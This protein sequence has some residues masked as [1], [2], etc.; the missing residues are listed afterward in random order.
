MDG[1]SASQASLSSRNVPVMESDNWPLSRKRRSRKPQE[2]F[3]RQNTDG[4]DAM[5]D[6]IEYG[7]QLENPAMGLNAV[8]SAGR[9]ISSLTMGQEACA[10]TMALYQ[11]TVEA[12]Q[13]QRDLE[14]MYSNQYDSFGMNAAMGLSMIRPFGNFNCDDRLYRRTLQQ[15]EH[16]SEDH[17]MNSHEIDDEDQPEEE[18]EEAEDEYTDEDFNLY[19]DNEDVAGSQGTAFEVGDGKLSAASPKQLPS[20][21]LCELCDRTFKGRSQLASHMKTHRRPLHCEICSIRF[22]SQGTLLWHQRFVHATQKYNHTCEV[23]GE[24]LRLKQ[25]LM[26]HYMTHRLAKGVVRCECGQAFR[27]T[28]TLKL[29]QL[30]MCSSHSSDR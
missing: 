22:T 8:P 21:V 9:A 27:N 5:S 25:D 30:T 7:C 17:A 11:R 28:A 24:T 6:L 23:C 29:H 18:E 15:S 3:R 2:T 4:E 1:S 26:S 20:S 14:F 10:S 19:E 12:W 16:S 13:N